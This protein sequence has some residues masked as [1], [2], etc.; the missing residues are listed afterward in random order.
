MPQSTGLQRVRHDSATKQH[1]VAVSVNTS[2]LQNIPSEKTK[3]LF[4]TSKKTIK[5]ELH[6]KMEKTLHVPEF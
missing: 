6:R 1:K 5:H 4:I 3:W 2:S